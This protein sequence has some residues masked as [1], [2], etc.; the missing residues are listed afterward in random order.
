MEDELNNYSEFWKNKILKNIQRDRLV[1][2]NLKQDGWIVKRFWASKIL[3]DPNK[4]ANE[5]K[6]LYLSH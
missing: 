1:N 3:K 2:E 6:E 4:C 5:I